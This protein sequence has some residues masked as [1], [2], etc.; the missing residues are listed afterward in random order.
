MD[1]AR[2]ALPPE[3]RRAMATAELMGSVY[4]RLLEKLE[5][6]RFDV[7]HATP[8]R[9]TKAQKI[10]LIFRTWYRVWRGALVPN[11]GVQ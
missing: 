5:A 10:F 1:Q 6:R 2:E 8:T 3:D 11:Y 9:L 4:W 7:F